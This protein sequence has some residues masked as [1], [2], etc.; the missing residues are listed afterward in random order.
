MIPKKEISYSAGPKSFF[1][2]IFSF[3]LRILQ[4]K[5][6]QILE[7]KGSPEAD[8]NYFRIFGSKS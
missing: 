8:P 4:K 3:K 2:I 6:K 1:G 5:K 7:A